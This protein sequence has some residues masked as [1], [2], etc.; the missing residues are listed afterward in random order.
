MCGGD[1]PESAAIVDLL[2]GLVQR[3]L[4]VAEPTQDAMRYRLLETL[5]EYAVE[6]FDQ[7]EDS[8]GRRER[9]AR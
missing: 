3:S 7:A 2:A 6:G 9:H 8:Y 1:G 4:V 5:R